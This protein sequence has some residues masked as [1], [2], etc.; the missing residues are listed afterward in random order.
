[1]KFNKIPELSEHDQQVSI[2]Q[3]ADMM[4]EKHFELDLL[5]AIPNGGFRHKATARRLKA[6]GVKSGVPDMCLPV[7]RSGFN[8]LYIELKKKSNSSVPANQKWW[9]KMLSK[10]GYF[11]IVCRGE[12][13]AKKAIVD[14]LEGRSE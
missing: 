11:T 13:E 3:W 1:M 8:G 14:Y 4:S 6:E 5:F 12:E 9:L 2:F 10:Q 7:P